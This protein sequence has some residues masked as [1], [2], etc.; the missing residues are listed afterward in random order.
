MY[1]GRESRYV[2]CL[3]GNEATDVEGEREDT[4][5]QHH[6]RRRAHRQLLRDER[7]GMIQ[8]IDR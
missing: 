6:L 2:T 8:Y 7:R 4:G 3:V 1:S 5:E